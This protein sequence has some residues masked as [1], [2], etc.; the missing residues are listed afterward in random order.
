MATMKLAGRVLKHLV[1][2]RLF[3]SRIEF[4]IAVR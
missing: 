1:V 3:R 2:H 4:G